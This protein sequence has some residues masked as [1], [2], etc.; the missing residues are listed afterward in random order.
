MALEGKTA[1]VT[2][3]SR[4]IGN[5]IVLE[6][7]RE[8][9]TVY[10]VSRAEPGNRAE[11]EAAC[12]NGT[13][14]VWKQ[15]DVTKEEE[16]SKIME[17]ISAEAGSI[18]VLVNNA[19]ITR[20]GLIFRMPT[21]SWEEVLRAN[22]TSAFFTSRAMAR[23]MIRQKTGSIINISSVSGITG[24]AGQTNYSASKAGLIG[25]SKSLAREIAPRGVRVNVIAPGFIETD[26]TKAL[27]DKAREALTVQIP[28]GRVGA[29]EDVAALAAFLASDRAAY[30]TGQVFPV[31]GGLSM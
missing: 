15:A 26:M 21:E 9:A 2:G 18:E 5:A 27:G 28:L 8:G 12:R 25:F 19:G 20:D 13:R 24:N 10:A 16:I 11:L 22:L 31:D 14:Y 6:F 3:G 17:E 30:I 1:I 29:P 4:G 23:L 7:L